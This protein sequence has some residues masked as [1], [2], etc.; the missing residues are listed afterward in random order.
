M[1]FAPAVAI[2]LIN[3]RIFIRIFTSGKRIKVLPYRSGI[4]YPDKLLNYPPYECDGKTTK[5]YGSL[6]YLQ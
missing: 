1:T 4:T 5:T 2:K 6:N 3:S